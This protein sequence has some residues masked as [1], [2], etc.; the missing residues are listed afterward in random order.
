MQKRI[1]LIYLLYKRTK[2]DLNRN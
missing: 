1:F 2:H